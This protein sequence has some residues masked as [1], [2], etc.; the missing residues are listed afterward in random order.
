MIH[1]VEIDTQHRAR[2]WFAFDEADF[3]RKVEIDRKPDPGETVYCR[4]SAR[5]LLSEAAGNAAYVQQLAAQH[6]WDTPLYRADFLLERGLYRSE[7]VSEL[8]ACLAAVASGHDFRIYADDESASD[9]L[10]RDP[11]FKSREGLDAYRK[12]RS[13]LVEMEVIAEDF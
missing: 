1:I 4:T 2:V 12:L 3:I 7:P 5:Q 6:G 10:D 11:L 9:E 8:R 13:Q